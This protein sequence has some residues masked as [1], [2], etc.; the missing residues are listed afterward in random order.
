MGGLGKFF[1]STIGIIIETAL[2]IA[3]IANPSSWVILAIYIGYKVLSMTSQYL[4]QKEQQRR[5][6][7]KLKAGN[8]HLLDTMSSVERI[9]LVYGTCRVG[10]NIVF[11]KTDGTDNQYLYQWR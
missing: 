10:G 2:V 11:R 7:E 4:Y 8:G 1:G 9:P 6:Q 3:A 5:L